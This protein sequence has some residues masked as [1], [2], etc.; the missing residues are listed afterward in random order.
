MSETRLYEVGLHFTVDD[1]LGPPRKALHGALES[2]R[3]V[4]VEASSIEE[5]EAQVDQIRAALEREADGLD[6]TG[7]LMFLI[8]DRSGGT[9][10]GN[11]PSE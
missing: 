10:E 9:Q 8:A 2:V 6:Y 7:R 11:Q 1:G 4:L 5:A 3:A